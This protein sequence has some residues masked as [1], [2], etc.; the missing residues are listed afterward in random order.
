VDDR[1]GLDW[2][3][4]VETRLGLDMSN[5][6]PD[7]DLSWAHRSSTRC[8]L[9]AAPRRPDGIGCQQWSTLWARSRSKLGPIDGGS[10]EHQFAWRFHAGPTALDRDESSA[11]EYQVGTQ[12]LRKLSFRHFSF[13]I[14][15]QCSHLLYDYQCLTS[16]ITERYV[17]FSIL[18][19]VHLSSRLL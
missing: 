2:K 3:E 15:G 12:C 17:G 11:R 7:R 13:M 10:W 9:M 19:F 1:N 5:F 14:D 4:E 6:G 18:D 16:S 8:R